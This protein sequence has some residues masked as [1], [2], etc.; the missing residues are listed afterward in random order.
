MA[1]AANRGAWWCWPATPFVARYLRLRL[2]TTGGDD[3]A[4]F[5]RL[6]IGPDFRPAIQASRSNH[7]RGVMTAG[8]VER[9]AVSGIVTAQRGAT[10]RASRFTLPLLSNAEAVEVETAALAVGTHGQIIA[11]PRTQDGAASLLLGRF[12]APPEPEIV[13]PRRW[14][15]SLAVLE[16]L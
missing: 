2:L 3:Y 12:E 13:A 6:W 16:D 5:G 10:Y 11:N 15:A 8:V 1:L 14:S 4:Q 7:R 9:A